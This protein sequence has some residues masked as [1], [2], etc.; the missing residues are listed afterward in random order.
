MITYILNIFSGSLFFLSKVAVTNNAN[1]QVSYQY[2]CLYIF[3][4]FLIIVICG[5]FLKNVIWFFKMWHSVEPLIA[6]NIISTLD[7]CGATL[8]LYCVFCPA[9]ALCLCIMETTETFPLSYI[10]FID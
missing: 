4:Y 1:F 3:W 7:L 5:K 2:A 6:C 8:G 10:N 9:C